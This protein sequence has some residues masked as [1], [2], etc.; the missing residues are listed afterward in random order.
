M[1]N[2][3]DRVRRFTLCVRQSRLDYAKEQS[4]RRGVPVPDLF[5]HWIDIGIEEDHPP[6]DNVR[7][8]VL[9]IKKALRSLD[10]KDENGLV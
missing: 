2:P 3:A 1:R 9:S 5:R 10:R 7:E 4:Q 6:S 8:A